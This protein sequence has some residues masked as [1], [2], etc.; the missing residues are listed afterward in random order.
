MDSRGCA[1]V[2]LVLILAVLAWGVFSY[3]PDS[4]IDFPEL[5]WPTIK[6]F[7]PTLGSIQ[8]AVPTF[9]GS[10]PATL[11]PRPTITPFPTPVVRTPR[12]GRLLFAGFD[13]SI[14]SAEVEG[15][16]A[17]RLGMMMQS[18]IFSSNPWYSPDGR[19]AL[20]ARNENN[21]QFVYLVRTD[22]KI[23]ELRLGP[24]TADFSSNGPRDM[25]AFASDGR[26][27]F[28]IDTSSNPGTMV[29]VL[30]EDFKSFRWPV[31]ASSEEIT[32][33]S[34]WGSSDYILLKSFDA[35]LNAHYLELFRVGDTLTEPHRVAFQEG[36]QIR[37]FVVS[38]DSV[39][40]AVVFRRFGDAQS[41]ELSIL[42]F[43]TGS[44]APV[45][46][47]GGRIL[48]PSPAWSADGRYLL[49]SRWLDTN[50]SYEY[51][52]F[53]VDSGVGVTASLFG[54][55][56]VSSYGQ[57][58]CQVVSFA[59]D[60][61]GVA[62]RLYEDLPDEVS[63]SLLLMDGSYRREIARYKLENGIPE[64][65]MAV[66]F[67]ADWTKA[68]MLELQAGNP[69]GSL[70]VTALD[71]SHRELLDNRVPYEFLE[72]GPVIS[73]DGKWVALLH[74]T[75]GSDTARLS[76]VRLDG[77]EHRE[78]FSGSTYLGGGE[79]PAGLPIVWLPTP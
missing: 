55:L 37:Q 11:T 51:T 53:G 60:G 72:L 78:L 57:P 7:L 15:G 52:L 34:F 30:L 66:G 49:F 46:R 71:G 58:F 73:P 56:Q 29:V 28:Y 2:M 54:P 63:T 42:N 32:F 8:I 62:V 47:S 74:Y 17:T 13:G 35:N 64:G 77:N 67:T 19:F 5:S 45:D 9:E 76:I 33:A 22:G 27:F 21:S 68:V 41:D 14:W 12:N 59:P 10:L 69:F 1:L 48:L 40:A 70:Y 39:H 44:I 36:Y 61:L 31:Q 43:R 20:V 16:S 75:E 4:V 24:V 3:A 79:A 65:L 26:R 23:P 50:G 38:P 6:S 18:N 25:F